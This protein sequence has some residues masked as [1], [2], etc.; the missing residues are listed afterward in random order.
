[1]EIGTAIGKENNDRKKVKSS[2]G[3][4]FEN[5]N[6]DSNTSMKTMGRIRDRGRL[7]TW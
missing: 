7:V 6:I 3:N 4:S 2:N 5:I 1:M